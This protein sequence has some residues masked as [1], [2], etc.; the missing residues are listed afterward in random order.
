MIAR[1]RFPEIGL[2][3]EHTVV[4][5]DYH[6]STRT[7]LAHT[8]PA[9]RTPPCGRLF[10]RHAA[11]AGYQPIEAPTA[12]TTVE[13]FVL[14]PRQPVLYFLAYVYRPHADGGWLGD[15]DALYRFDL[16]EHRCERLVG[17]DDLPAPRGCERAW[18]CDLLSVGADGR[19]L[20]CRA[21]LQSPAT[22]TL[23]TGPVTGNRA[24]YW[25]ARLDLVTREL[26]AVSELAALRA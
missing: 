23:K 22:F 17:P 12:G 13:S 16:G 10:F 5:L 25:V 24:D 7:V 3:A 20:F 9:T 19:G 4:R 6:E 1:P 11:D 26:T 18:L 8:G 21:G 15:W 14:D 2:P